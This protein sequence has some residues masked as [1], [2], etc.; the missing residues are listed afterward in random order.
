MVDLALLGATV[1]SADTQVGAWV[2]VIGTVE[3]TTGT[4]SGGQGEK[5]RG[6]GRGER[7]E[8]RV[9]AVLLWSAGGIRLDEY[10]KAVEGREASEAPT[11]RLKA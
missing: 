7:Q 4:R 10:E 6:K 11:T 8:V 2:N 9:K 5:G 1:K 3:E